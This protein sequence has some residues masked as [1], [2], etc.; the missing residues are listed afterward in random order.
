MQNFFGYVLGRSGNQIIVPYR[1]D[2]M[3][4]RNLRPMSPVARVLALPTIAQLAQPVITRRTTR[5]WA[6]VDV[7]SILWPTRAVNVTSRAAAAT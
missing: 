1:G 5:A 2:E 3:D 6:N 7:A 4:Y